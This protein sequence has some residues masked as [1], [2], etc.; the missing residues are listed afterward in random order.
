MDKSE[1]AIISNLHGFLFF[2]QITLRKK[3]NEISSLSYKI[4]IIKIKL[5]QIKWKMFDIYRIQ[6]LARPV[7]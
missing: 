3:N 6:P 1:Y 5:N 4:V 7:D 2:I